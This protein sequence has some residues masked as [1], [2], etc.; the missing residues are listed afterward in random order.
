[1]MIEVRE[2]CTQSDTD[3]EP[4]SESRVLSFKSILNV[5]DCFAGQQDCAPC[6]L[7]PTEYCVLLEQLTTA[8]K[9]QEL[10][11]LW[12]RAPR[13]ENL[14]KSLSITLPI[15]PSNKF[16]LNSQM[17]KGKYVNSIPKYF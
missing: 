2:G 4:T 17:L 14:R 13:T 10:V 11:L 7:L 1:M 15:S 8:P 16:V 3:Q 6:G 9:R 5:Y 12:S